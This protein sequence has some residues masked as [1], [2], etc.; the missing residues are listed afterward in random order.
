[1][2]IGLLDSF[3][4]WPAPQPYFLH[5]ATE[6]I[7]RARIWPVLRSDNALILYINCFYFVIHNSF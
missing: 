2:H 1:M 7:G 5:D 4:T 6:R 3:E